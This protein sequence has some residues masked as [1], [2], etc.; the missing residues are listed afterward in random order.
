VAGSIQYS[1]RAWSLRGVVEHPRGLT[2]G[3]GSPVDLSEPMKES[4][5]PNEESTDGKPI[6]EISQYK[7]LDSGVGAVICQ[8]SGDELREG[9]RV[10]AFACCSESAGYEIDEVCCRAHECEYEWSWDRSRRE[11]IVR[12]RIGTVSDVAMQSSWPV[13]LEPEVVAFS[14]AGI[15]EAYTLDE[16]GRDHGA[17]DEDA[18]V[19][20]TRS[21]VQELSGRDRPS[22]WCDGGGSR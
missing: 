12:G 22:S 1:V 15:E 17:D 13:L 5:P 7:Q 2:R 19:D 3:P 14:P 9:E 21:L 6:E 4:T 16:S 8:F 20:V 18:V 11:V 10:S